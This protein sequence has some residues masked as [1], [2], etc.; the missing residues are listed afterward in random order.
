[1]QALRGTGSELGGAIDYADQAG[2]TLYPTLFGAALPSGTVHRGAFESMVGRLVE[3]LGSADRLDAVVLAVHGAMVVD[4]YA[5]PESV[6]LRAVRSVVGAI[7]IAVTLDYH[8]NLGSE[9]PSLA[10][11]LIGYR[12]YPHTDMADRGAEAMELAARAVRGGRRPQVGF[13]KLPLL[14]VPVSQEDAA[15]PMR[16]IL[17][18]VDEL[19]GRDG[20][21][22]VSALPGFA[23]GDGRR[24]GFSVYVC[25]MDRAQSLA[26]ELAGLGL[27]QSRAVRLRPGRPGGGGQSGAVGAVPA[28]AGRRRGQRGRWLARQRHGDPARAGRRRHSG[29]CRR[30]LGSGGSRCSATTSRSRGTFEIGSP[31]DPSMGPPFVATGVIHRHGR[32]VYRRSGSYMRGQQVDMGEVVVLDIGHRPD[33]PHR[34]SGGAVR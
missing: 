24:L 34:E 22:T 26:R 3:R 21:S 29:R 5:D 13:V 7:P 20:V 8:A 25:A 32:V 2:I 18:S 30:A 17:R 4:G 19:V 28:G 12:T 6:L 16:S 11:F 27:V 9:L 14:T 23:Y 1:M 15:E 31:D 10:D 33:R